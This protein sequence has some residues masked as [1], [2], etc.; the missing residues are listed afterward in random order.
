LRAR[1]LYWL[2]VSEIANLPHRLSDLR[3]AFQRPRANLNPFPG[4]QI[5]LTILTEGIKKRRCV[6]TREAPAALLQP[7]AICK[8]MLQGDGKLLLS[9]EACRISTR[10][11]CLIS[12]FSL[13][14]AFP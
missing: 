1:N 6:A 2:R 13:F 7:S 9:P 8:G 11:D 12:S 4:L 3:R 5:E 10:K 14:S